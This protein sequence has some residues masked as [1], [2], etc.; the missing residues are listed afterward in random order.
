MNKVKKTGINIFI[1]KK[2][3]K[4]EIVSDWSQL[5]EGMA[6]KSLLVRYT[7]N[8]IEECEKLEKDIGS[9]QALST[10]IAGMKNIGLLKVSSNPTA[11]KTSK[12]CN[13]LVK[14]VNYS[15]KLMHEYNISSDLIIKTK[16]DVYNIK[17][18]K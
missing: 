18:I 16:M 1:D 17:S 10:T 2:K 13:T 11:Q 3:N 7:Q 4:K 6:L 15:G 9:D 5:K 12:A 8:H 14:L